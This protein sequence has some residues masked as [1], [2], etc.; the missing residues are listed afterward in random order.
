MRRLPPLGDEEARRLFEQLYADSYRKLLAYSIQRTTTREDADDVVAETFLVA[1]RRLE[2]VV[3][4]DNPLAWLYGVAHRVI[5][6]QR[7]SA[8]R[9]T[10]LAA[11]L[12]GH[13][14][15]GSFDDPTN[16]IDAKVRVS[17]VEAALRQLP[18]RYQEVLRL[19]AYQEQSPAEIATTLHVPPPAV[20]TLLYRARIRLQKSLD[21]LPEE[22][23]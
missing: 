6:N 23:R 13:D 16:A 1:W 21:L 5:S 10:R 22:T 7:R 8:F 18:H 11:I 12:E 4:T 15:E 19:A 14:I 20:R 2:E 9:R 17:Q 3:A